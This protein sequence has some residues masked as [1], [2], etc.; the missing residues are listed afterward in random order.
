MA[1][2]AAHD[3]SRSLNY[4][5]GQT[6]EVRQY[7]SEIGPI[8]NYFVLTERARWQNQ[9]SKPDIAKLYCF[10]RSGRHSEYGRIDRNGVSVRK[11]VVS[12]RILFVLEYLCVYS[13]CFFFWYPLPP[14]LCIQL[15]L[16]IREVII[17]LQVRRDQSHINEET[18]GGCL[19]A[20]GVICV[21]VTMRCFTVDNISRDFPIVAHFESSR[22]GTDPSVA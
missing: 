13:N 6:R 2:E 4:R 17:C 20:G 16:A 10:L 22:I 1:L 15:E 3:Q 7:F 8:P 21:Y 11:E 12:E 14:I 9:G 18:T 5:E 19:I